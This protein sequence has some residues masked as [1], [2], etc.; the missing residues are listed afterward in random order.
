MAVNH[1]FGRR[2]LEKLDTCHHDLKQLA[3]RALSMSPYDFTIVHGWRN[4]DMQNMLVESGVSRTP[5]PESKHNYV[6]EATGSP[7]SMAIDFAP[8]V[9]RGIPWEDTHIFAV[10]AGCFFAAASD[11]G[12][13]IRW[14]GDWDSDGLTSDQTLLDYGHVELLT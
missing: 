3:F 4:E 8:W 12:I 1:R 5:W 13:D 7:C 2:S 14:G 9:N 6:D 10:V 11:M